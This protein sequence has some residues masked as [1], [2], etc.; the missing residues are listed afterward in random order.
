MSFWHFFFCSVA[1]QAPSWGALHLS[2]L[3]VPSAQIV[4][5][6]ILLVWWEVIKVRGVSGAANLWRNGVN[7]TQENSSRGI[8]DRKRSPCSPSN[9]LLCDRSSIKES[10]SL[11]L[12]L[13]LP[14]SPSSL[15]LSRSNQT[16]ALLTLGMIGGTMVLFFRP[17]QSKD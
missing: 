6:D 15:S 16:Q 13:S 2:K 8:E 3:L 7:N 10:T 11:S 4:R 12:S 5:R 14:P 1:A 17:S 9:T